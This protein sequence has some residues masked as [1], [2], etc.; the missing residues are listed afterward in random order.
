MLV[1]GNLSL[2]R[3]SWIECAV[4]DVDAPTHRMNFADAFTD[5]I[6]KEGDPSEHEKRVNSGNDLEGFHGE[7]FES[8]G[9]EL[10]AL[11]RIPP[12]ST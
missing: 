6:Q 9:F 5:V 1:G 8:S 3:R 4:E 2:S 7:G 11:L 10:Q 12:L